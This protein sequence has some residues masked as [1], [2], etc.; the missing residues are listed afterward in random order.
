MSH[1][2]RG[3]GVELV[4]I[5]KIIWWITCPE[6]GEI[7]YGISKR[8]DWM[9]LDPCCTNEKC[10]HRMIMGLT[11]QYYYEKVQNRCS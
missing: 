6:C 9:N 8:N 4:T 11:N 1:T 3:N 10:N 5:E 7:T 2:I